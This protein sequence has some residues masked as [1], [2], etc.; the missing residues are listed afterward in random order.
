MK[1]LIFK[2]RISADRK[3]RL[4]SSCEDTEV[5]GLHRFIRR[6]F[7]CIVKDIITKPREVP[8]QVYISKVSDRFRQKEHFFCRIKSR[9]SITVNERLF[10][11]LFSHSLI[12]DLS[13]M[14]T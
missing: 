1:N 12:I 4:I 13:S 7:V 5:E 6:H 14:S 10:L 11:L 2:N 3:K 9:A 8:P